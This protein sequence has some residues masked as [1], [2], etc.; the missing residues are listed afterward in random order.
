M[1]KNKLIILCSL[2]VISILFFS[3]KNSFGQINPALELEGGDAIAV[4]IIPNPEHYS[5]SRWYESRGFQGSP[6]SL[7]I[8]GYEAIR[9]GRT[10]YVNA[11][12]VKGK[13]IFTNVYLISYNQDPS[14]KT[15]D[16]LGQIVKNWK[17]N[18]DLKESLSP[19]PSCQISS[20]S[21]SS[22][23]DCSS[24]QFCSQS[25][26]ASS[27]CQL[28]EV[29]NCLVDS[30]CPQSFYCNSVKSKIVRDIERISKISELKE[31]IN[32]YKT[33]RGLYP[34]LEAGTYLRGQAI[35]TWPSWS[36]I[37]LPELGTDKKFVDPINRLGSCPGYDEQTCWDK[38]R[39]LFFSSTSGNLILPYA[40]YAMVYKTNNGL[41]YNLCASME[42][43]SSTADLGFSF[44]PAIAQDSNCISDTGVISGSSIVN[45]PPRLISA[46]L[47]GET[48][49]EFN[50]SLEFFDDQNNPMT[51]S[52]N[53]FG[54]PKVD[55]GWSEN[56]VLVNT[57]NPNRKRIYASRAGDP[58]NYPMS[59]SVNDGQGGVYS[60]TTN[61]KILNQKPVI[62]ASDFEYSL[63][64]NDIFSYSFYFSSNSIDNYQS[65]FSLARLNG[66]NPFSLLS[67]SKSVVPAG[68]GRYKVTYSG[69]VKNAQSGAP[70]S[71]DNYQITVK[72]KY[73]WLSN[74]ASVKNFKITI[75]NNPPALNFS[76][77]NFNRV[78]DGYSCLIGPAQSLGKQINYSTNSNF[79]GLYLNTQGDSVFLLSQATNLTGNI[80][81]STITISA[82]NQNGA[83][84]QKSFKLELKTFCGD[85]IKQTPNT[86]ARGG[87]FNDG[88]EDCDGL[89]GISLTANGSSAKSQ[90]ACTT[91]NS[92][93][94][95]PITSGNYCI[96]QSPVKGGGFCGD[97][98]CTVQI[99]NKDNCPA[100][101][102]SSCVP[103][104]SRLNN[105]CGDDGCGGS[106][107]TCQTGKDECYGGKCCSP[108]SKI[109]ILNYMPAVM[110]GAN[111]SIYLNGK[112]PSST[113]ASSGSSVQII[114]GSYDGL[115]SHG[116]NVLAI[117]ASGFKDYQN[118]LITS[119]TQSSYVEKNICRHVTT[120]DLKNWKCTNAPLVD[121]TGKLWYDL[122]YNDS[123]WT[124]P[125]SGFANSYANIWSNDYNVTGPFDKVLDSYC[126]YSF[127]GDVYNND[128][129][130]PES[131]NKE[132]GPNKCGGFFRPNNCSINN[133][134]NMKFACNDSTNLCECANKVTCNNGKPL[135]SEG[136]TCGK[137]SDN[138][139]GTNSCGYNC[140]VGLYCNLPDNT[141]T[142]LFY[143]LSGKLSHIQFLNNACNVGKP[144]NTCIK[145]CWNKTFE[146]S[147]EM[148]QGDVPET[149]I[150]KLKEINDNPKCDYNPNPTCPTSCSIKTP[151]NSVS[152]SNGVK[153]SCWTKTVL[154][155][156][157]GWKSR[158]NWIC[159]SGNTASKKWFYD[160]VCN[161][162]GYKVNDNG[163]CGVCQ[164][165]CVGASCGA[166]DGCGGICLRGA[167][168]SNEVCSNGSCTNCSANCDGK[169]CGE[170][171][172]C[173]GLC[174]SGICDLGES[175]ENNNCVSCT[176]NCDNKACG[177]SDGCGGKCMSGSCAAGETCVEGS[178][179]C[180]K[181]CD[182]KAC[183]ASDGCGGKCNGSCSPGKTCQNYECVTS[184]CT[185]DC[186]NKACGASDGCGGKCAG[187]CGDYEMC[188]KGSC[189]KTWLCKG[190]GPLCLAA[191]K[192][193]DCVAPCQ[194][195]WVEI[196]K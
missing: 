126:R 1:K 148:R 115:I 171:D 8:D 23:D 62:E 98:F 119:L 124:V 178:C 133:V 88:N 190:I 18:T 11:A 182:N 146:L 22:S 31:I 129:C 152:L 161:S 155:V 46:S 25:G 15:V 35:S 167:C 87:M 68:P 176:S 67:L 19:A 101:C 170:P 114:P 163:D 27:S 29:K 71:E 191:E 122:D 58:I 130:K 74:D 196:N 42:T 52:I 40:S 10:V 48:G 9:D 131:I 60:T 41:D 108:K 117:K 82:S 193:T 77:S 136:S 192:F 177:A 93:T 111:F 70:S 89:S 90:Y 151:V 109:E 134:G 37:F 140:G 150:C 17:F 102:V 65:A 145:K 32:N 173:S 185:P 13:T 113:P 164:P 16:I 12:N 61:I 56:P 144:Y 156:K 174:S 75:K 153:D 64:F 59:I 132:C 78:R 94:P 49:Q 73:Y 7:R 69:D 142:K 36:E 143:T 28:K 125:N 189:V 14:I 139:G 160:D 30:D 116:K 4:R 99:E 54:N 181:N 106:C 118:A 84:T 3:T 51:W 6:Q 127:V 66:N 188:I 81:S 72:D 43:K 79:A 128:S 187:G 21:C 149:N 186:T 112:K 95:N 57:S 180:V 100:D 97:T 184:T 194:I 168:L 159:S 55:S 166:D 137:F 175:C 47:V 162:L 20:L 26:L 105:D 5:I 157:S 121:G 76:C 33:T 179:V 50:G 44:S 2:F 38:N 80:S 92:A 104:C 86:E 135:G 172:G 83:S 63:G 183:G 147:M 158:K 141:E 39:K 53:V 91:I 169:A 107:G 110:T 34:V 165:N 103:N 195:E 123:S 120:D 85:G 24:D 96:F 154:F 45:T 138:C